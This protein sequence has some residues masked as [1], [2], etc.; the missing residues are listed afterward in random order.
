V[1]GQRH[2]FD[3]VGFRR[4]CVRTWGRQGL[5]LFQEQLSQFFNGARDHQA[6]IRQIESLRNGPGK[7]ERFRNNH[8]AGLARKMESHVVAEHASVIPN[9]HAKA[10]CTRFVILIRFLTRA[11]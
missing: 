7:I 6:G 1:N 5:A 11:D 8:F 2:K 9:S 4:R 10:A 3:Q